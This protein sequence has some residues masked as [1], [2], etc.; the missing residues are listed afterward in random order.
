MKN[1]VTYTASVNDGILSVSFSRKPR[2]SVRENIRGA[3]LKYDAAS[4]AWTGKPENPASVLEMLRETLGKPSSVTVSVDP[5][6]LPEAAP[7]NG[8]L[9]EKTMT[10]LEPALEELETA[11]RREIEST[12]AETVPEPETRVPTYEEARAE[13][14]RFTAAKKAAED[15]RDAAERRYDEISDSLFRYADGQRRCRRDM[16]DEELAAASEALAPLEKERSAAYA[17]I[18]RLEMCIRYASQNVDRAFFDRYAPDAAKVFNRYAGKPFGPKTSEKITAEIYE[19]TGLTVTFWRGDSYRSG[20]FTFREPENA[21]N[22][23]RYSLHGY[24]GS[25]FDAEGKIAGF[26]LSETPGDIPREYIPDIPS[27]VAEAENLYRQI[28]EAKSA[29][30]TL[31]AKYNNLLPFGDRGDRIYLSL[32]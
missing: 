23:R 5:E 13:L 11:V 25:L 28:K 2:L 18:E 26:D 4:T 14:E 15:A 3:G 24:L 31:C 21:W 10:A 19:L 7:E 16:T 1:P 9:T 29:L 32:R 30:D 27:R 20:S 12:I 22:D 8:S 17:E 6:E